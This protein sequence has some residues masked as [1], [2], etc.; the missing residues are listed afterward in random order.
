MLIR[1]R[2]I[3]KWLLAVHI[4]VVLAV[5]TALF[6]VTSSAEEVGT[7]GM[8]SSARALLPWMPTVPPHKRLLCQYTCILHKKSVTAFPLK[9]EL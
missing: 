9:R 3:K 8:A 4:L 2:R 5:M 7:L 6:A 1:E